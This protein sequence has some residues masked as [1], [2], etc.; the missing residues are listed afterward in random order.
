VLRIAFSAVAASDIKEL[1]D[2]IYSACKD[3]K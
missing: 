1:F 2:G 3:C